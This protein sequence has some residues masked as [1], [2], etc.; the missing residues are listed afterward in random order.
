M[1]RHRKI[2]KEVIVACLKLQCPY[3]FAESK[4]YIVI[5][6]DRRQV[7]RCPHQVLTSDIMVLPLR[8]ILTT[9]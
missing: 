5:S 9:N 3:L 2:F 6:L 1:G 8:H 7:G 4:K